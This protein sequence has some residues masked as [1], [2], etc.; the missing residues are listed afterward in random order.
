MLE[1]PFPPPRI[2]SQTVNENQLSCRHLEI[3]GSWTVVLHELYQIC[4]FRENLAPLDS[5]LD[6]KDTAR[7]PKQ[8]QFQRHRQES[9]NPKQL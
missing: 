3:S 9:R 8:C 6:E 5:Q 4:P 7:Q 1:L 2:F